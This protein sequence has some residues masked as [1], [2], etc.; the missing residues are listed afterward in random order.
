MPEETGVSSSLSDEE[1]KEYIEEV[2]AETQKKKS[3]G[4]NP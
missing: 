2:L 1:I 4:G 3:Q